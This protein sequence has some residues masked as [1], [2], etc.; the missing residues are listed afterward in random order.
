M[1]KDGCKDS[2]YSI[3]VLCSKSDTLFCAIKFVIFS[4][5]YSVLYNNA[6]RLVMREGGHF[7]YT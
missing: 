2:N 1:G 6:V 3:V 5:D 7:T 4:N